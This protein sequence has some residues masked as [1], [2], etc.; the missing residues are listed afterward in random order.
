MTLLPV[1]DEPEPDTAGLNSAL[2]PVPTTPRRS[3]LW[4][5]LVSLIPAI[6]CAIM[7]FLVRSAD[8]CQGSQA[9]V[10]TCS[11]TPLHGR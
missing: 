10:Y 9:T 7:L 4:Y 3:L 11:A 8:A 6:A 2:A 1:I 5:L